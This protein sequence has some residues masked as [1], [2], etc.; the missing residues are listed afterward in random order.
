MIWWWWPTSRLLLRH[1]RRG[2]ASWTAAHR[3]YAAALLHGAASGSLD[4]WWLGWGF[5]KI[6]LSLNGTACLLGAMAVAGMQTLARR[7]GT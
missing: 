4:P 5:D 7:N 6:W 1:F 3:A 2:V